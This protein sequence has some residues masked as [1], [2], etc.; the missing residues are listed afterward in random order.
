VAD[1]WIVRPIDSVCIESSS[2]ELFLWY[3]AMPYQTGLVEDRVKLIDA[4]RVGRIVL[5]V[6]EQRDT[7]GVA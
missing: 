7:T 6:K 2:A 4:N 5:G 1:G 3:S